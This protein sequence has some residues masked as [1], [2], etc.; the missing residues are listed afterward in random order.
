MKFIKTMKLAG[1]A[2]A[3]SLLAPIGASASTTL[4]DAQ[5]TQCAAG[6]LTVSTATYVSC[7]GAFNLVNNW[8]NDDSNIDLLMDRFGVTNWMRYAKISSD[9][10]TPNNG[11]S[12]T[13]GIGANI[14]TFDLNGLTGDA[15]I[16]VKGSTCFSAY[17]FSGLTGDDDGSFNTY[18]AGLRTNSECDGRNAPGISNLT[19]IKIADVPLPAAGFLLIAGLGGLA[20]VR[21]R[22]TA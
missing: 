16:V 15:V 3:L 13:S 9:A 18:L 22:K 1:A 14:G 5:R 8:L 11:L 21:R 17:R 19:V 7:Q 2:L 20:A 10:W 12:L 4:D 6:G